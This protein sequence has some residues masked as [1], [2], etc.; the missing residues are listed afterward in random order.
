MFHFSASSSSPS[1][2]SSTPKILIHAIWS[3]YSYPVNYNRQ[4]YLLESCG[5]SNI[6][7]QVSKLFEFHTDL[8]YVVFVLLKGTWN[9]ETWSC[10]RSQLSQRAI[11]GRGPCC[12]RR[13]RAALVMGTSLRKGRCFASSPQTESKISLLEIIQVPSIPLFL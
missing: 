6:F 12:S 10:L 3:I 8:R 2:T 9:M 5:G 7:C 1:K 4:N 13:Q 11:A